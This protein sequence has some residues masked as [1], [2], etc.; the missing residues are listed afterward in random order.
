MRLRWARGLYAVQVLWALA[1]GRGRGP[2]G[3]NADDAG[4]DDG[5]AP[6]ATPDAAD[7]APDAPFPAFKPDIGV[8]VNHGGPT[9]AAPEIMTVTWSSDPLGPTLEHF[10]AALGNSTYW[11]A[12]REYGIVS[13]TAWPRPVVVESPPPALD[14]VALQ[15]W[16]AAEAASP[17]SGWPAPQAN[18]VYAVYT[19][20]DAQVTWGGA[21]VCDVTQDETVSLQV[22]GALN[23]FNIA[24]GACLWVGTTQE[25]SDTAAGGVGLGIA[26]TDP[27]FNAW[28]GYDEPHY[29]WE[30]FVDGLDQISLACTLGQ[31]GYVRPEADLSFAV[32]RL[33][34]NAH[35][36]AGEDPCVP[37][38]PGP[39]FN[40]TP[41]GMTTM[42]VF[43]GWH[44]VTPRQVKAKGYRIPPGKTGT[45]QVGLFSDGPTSAWG[46]QAV[47]GDGTSAPS[48]PVLDI[49]MDKSSGVNGDIVTMTVKVKAAPAAQTAELMTVIS[50][51]GEVQHSVPILIGTY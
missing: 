13:T 49:A 18:T 28:T 45:F 30:L 37:P 5:A 33:W 46:I 48:E 44:T 50:T 27:Y 41:L 39:Y 34:S 42:R 43:V 7:A 32:P 4:A 3:S 40:A 6:D 47:E 20:P 35:A 10:D 16:L 1:C 15:E 26:A 38:W 17:T 12:L 22:G 29:A 25:D 21:D 24:Y 36:L 9:Y 51:Q 31:Q 23:V 11:R 2:L 14:H 19:P 8:I